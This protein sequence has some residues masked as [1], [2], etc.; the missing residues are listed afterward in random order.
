MEKE[1]KFKI[2]ADYAENFKK[3]ENSN[4]AS[5]NDHMYAEEIQQINNAICQMGYNCSIFGGVETLLAAAN[6]KDILQEYYF[7]N[8]SDGLTQSY[9]RLQAPVLCEIL[10]LKYSGSSP[11]SVALMNNK[12]YSKM[13]VE[14]LHIMVPKGILIECSTDL[15]YI[16]ELRFP[17]IL[18]PNTGGSSEGITQDCIKYS[19]QEAI[20][21][22][23]ELLKR[24]YEIIAEEYVAGY[25]ATTL[26]IGNKDDIKIN[27]TIVYEFDNKLYH[28]SDVLDANYKANNNRIGYPAYQIFSLDLCNKIRE[29][30]IKIFNHFQV[31]EI[32]RID[33]RITK[34][35]EIYFIEINSQP[36]INKGS[37][38]GYIC[39]F[40][41]I[42]FGELYNKYI[43]T[44][45]KRIE[46]NRDLE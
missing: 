15:S 35:G 45:L 31:N 40:Q 7:L 2:I 4:K 8:F 13:A 37:E 38:G 20:F 29:I 44:F 27:E 25:E 39:K 42:S 46:I 3:I 24:G 11:F 22:A 5:F 32:A 23:Q 1:R 21:K 9:S 16:N 36:G 34:D 26:I 30:S 17:I 14:E 41:G 43:Q 18:K 28:D 19:N 6:K 33:Y 10:N 12:H